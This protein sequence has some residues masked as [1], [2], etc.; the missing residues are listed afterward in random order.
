MWANIVMNAFV[1]YFK[2]V[3]TNGGPNLNGSVIVRGEWLADHTT[4][5]NVR[6]LSWKKVL[7]YVIPDNKH[8]YIDWETTTDYYYYYYHR[9]Y[10]R[11]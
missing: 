1:F 2:H 6:I 10:N 7:I 11:L 9:D 5:S 4:S 8:I 3:V